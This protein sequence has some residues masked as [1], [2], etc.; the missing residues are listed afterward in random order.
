MLERDVLVTEV[1]DENDL[2]ILLN[3]FNSNDLEDSEFNTSNCIYDLDDMTLQ[4]IVY[5]LQDEEHNF[6]EEFCS[7]FYDEYQERIY[8]KLILE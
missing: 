1:M 6:D 3:R 7:K 5:Y 2:I 8:E 4:R